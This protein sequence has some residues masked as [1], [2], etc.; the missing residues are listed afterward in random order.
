VLG[1]WLRAPSLGDHASS[2]TTR[3]GRAFTHDAAVV[4]TLFERICSWISR[5]VW[6]TRRSGYDHADT[7]PEEESMASRAE[8][9]AKQFEAK[10][11]EATTLVD[12]HLTS[13][14]ATVG[15]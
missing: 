6:Y 14:R 11:Q 3:R 9:L 5:A 8:T 4:Y 15:R 13:I 2:S 12:E 10:V 1:S 7:F